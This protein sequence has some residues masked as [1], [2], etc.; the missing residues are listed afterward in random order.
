MKLKIKSG[1]TPSTPV[2]GP[3]PSPFQEPAD[4]APKPKKTKA[5]RT[6]K[7]TQKVIESRKRKS[8]SETEGDDEGTIQVQPAAKKI[9]LSVL[10]PGPKTPITPGIQFKPKLKGKA[11]KRP[12]GEGY[13]SEASDR[14]DDPAIEEQFI[15]RMMPGDDCDYVRQAIIEKKIGLPRAPPHNGADISMKFFDGDGRKGIIKVRDNIYAT[16]LVDLPCVIEG[17]KSWDKR[18]WWKS[19]DI[20]QMLWVFAQVRSEEEARTIP[21]PSIVD[22]KTFQYPHG[23]TPP[24]HFARKRRFR[25]RLHKTQIEAVEAAVERLLKADREAEKS[26][27]TIIDPDAEER[28]ANQDWGTPGA[29]PGYEDGENQYSEDEDAPGDMDDAGAYFDTEHHEAIKEEDIG[30]EGIEDEFDALFEADHEEEIEKNSGGATPISTAIATPSQLAASTPAGEPSI[31]EED[32]GD[33]S[34]DSEDGE[35]D[36]GR[37]E[38]I[39]PE[40]QARLAQIQGTKE[41]IAQLEQSY[42]QVKAN[43]A[44]TTNILLKRRLEDNLKKLTNEIQL[45]KTS[46]GEGDD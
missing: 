28:R 36:D 20:C 43:L 32:S 5:G 17:M 24:M 2:P 42:A 1:S 46:I 27:Y 14:E 9:K 39:D 6:A 33:E 31:A 35:D 13:D 23:L 7:P 15:L 37:V 29:S 40:E 22:P 45:K 44:T 18:G 11:P 30:F 25:K 41:D 34:Y 10:N 26:T 4:E 19:A 12:M 16:T 38:E 21:I 8:E 3:G